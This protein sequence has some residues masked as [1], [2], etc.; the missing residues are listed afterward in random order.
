MTMST[1][2]Y[3][4]NAH[5]EDGVAVIEL[6]RPAAGNALDA[7]M[8]AGLLTAVRKVAA[9]GPEVRAVLLT[10]QGANFCTGQDLK[11]HARNLADGPGAA[12]ATV[13]ED[14]NP[15]VEAFHY[16]HPPVVCAI[17]G[18]CVGA[19][20]GIALCAD[21]RVAADSAHFATAFTKIGLAADSGLSRAL[22]QAVG[23]SRATGLLL[24]GERFGAKEAYDWG[25]VHRVTGSGDAAAQGLALAHELAA[26]PTVAYREAK[27]L[28]RDAATAD[29]RT[30]LDREA[31]A[32]E[33][34]GA[35]QDHR[36]AVTAF[37]SR[38][39]PTFHGR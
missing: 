19:G 21:I 5:V 39:R 32:Q 8:K 20:L 23:R 16:L 30:A 35:T 28:L 27:R 34:L 4:V 29:L 24:L 9:A 3:G 6:Q 18:A 33:V 22:T 17:E 12:F 2:E 37:L 13:R 31:A 1:S 38:Q 36:D 14:Y 7:V 26:G 25:L 10:A 15:L 11:E